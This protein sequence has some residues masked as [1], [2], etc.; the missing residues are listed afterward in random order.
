M[1]LIL[2]IPLLALALFVL[3]YAAVAWMLA[4]AVAERVAGRGD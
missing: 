1:K 3:W 4:V 2:L